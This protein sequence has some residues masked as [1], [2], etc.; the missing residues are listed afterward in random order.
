MARPIRLTF[1]SLALAL[2]LVVTVGLAACADTKK[3]DEEE[4]AKNTVACEYGGERVVIRFDAGEARM[5]IGADRV[6]L[7]Q[8]PSGSGI[9]YT[10]GLLE[11]RGKGT[12]MQLVRDGSSVPLNDCKPYVAPK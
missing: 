4:A 5:L 12:E 7:Y 3:K 6:T 1:A 10:N 11:L 9:R 8:I 2:T